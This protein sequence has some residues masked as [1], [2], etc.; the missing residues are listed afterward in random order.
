MTELGHMGLAPLASAV[1]DELVALFGGKVLY[2]IRR[3]GDMCRF[4]GE[5]YVYGL[6]NGEVLEGLDES[7]VEDF[8]F[9]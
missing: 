7:C 1:G 4:I 2:I 5:C 9:Y 6:M 3:E 8:V